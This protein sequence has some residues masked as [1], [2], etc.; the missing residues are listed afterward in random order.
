MVFAISDYRA[1]GS[2][3]SIL[4]AL[5]LFIITLPEYSRMP[6]Y[7]GIFGAVCCSS[8]ASSLSHYI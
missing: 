2:F 6:F 8:I 1:T 3:A 5:I 7:S 4:A